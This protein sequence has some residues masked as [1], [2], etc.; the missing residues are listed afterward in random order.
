MEDR[1]NR[2]EGESTSILIATARGLFSFSSLTPPTTIACHIWPQACEANRAIKASCG[3]F[4]II[5]LTEISDL[6]FVCG[7]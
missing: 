3:Q 5:S 2:D 7:A 6:F 4:N 1:A